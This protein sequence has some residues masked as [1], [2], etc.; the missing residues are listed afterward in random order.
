MNERIEQFL[1]RLREKTEAEGLRWR[2][3]QDGIIRCDIGDVECCPMSALPKRP[4]D[5]SL[6]SYSKA[7]R[8]LGLWRADTDAVMQA[9]DNRPWRD[10]E[11]RRALLQACGVKERRSACPT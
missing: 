9:A 8:H 11:L 6:V 5:A 4:Y 3:R 10:K 2:V 1:Q 7:R